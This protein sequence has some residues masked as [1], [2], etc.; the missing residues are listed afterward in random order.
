MTLETTAAA[1][2][3]INCLN[4]KFSS[5]QANKNVVTTLGRKIR[6]SSGNLT[7]I[8]F[9]VL[10]SIDK[11]RKLKVNWYFWKGQKI[12]LPYYTFF[13]YWEKKVESQFSQSWYKRIRWEYHRFLI[14]F[15]KFSLISFL[16]FNFK[17][18]KNCGITSGTYACFFLPINK[19][20]IS[21]P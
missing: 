8:F 14:A 7:H 3:K 15:L 6:V 4:C 13:I 10:I 21:L 16:F 9:R 18:C 20:T 1:I 17:S 2:T 12:I 19:I 11:F 5:L